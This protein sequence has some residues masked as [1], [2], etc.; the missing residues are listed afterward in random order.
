MR[1]IIIMPLAVLAGTLAVP[2][3]TQKEVAM[4]SPLMQS[5][6]VLPREVP[7]PPR[8]PFFWGGE[9]PLPPPKVQLW[10]SVG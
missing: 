2:S 5:R 9:H 3:P 1:V 8:R 6:V 4:R 7:L 10:S